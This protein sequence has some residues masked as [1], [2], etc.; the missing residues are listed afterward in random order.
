MNAGF[1]LNN[2]TLFNIVSKPNEYLELRALFATQREPSG[3]TDIV[4]VAASH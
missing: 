2:D 4:E 3:K 1:R